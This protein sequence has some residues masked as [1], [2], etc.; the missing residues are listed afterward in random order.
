MILLSDI[1]LFM[2]SVS[3]SGRFLYDESSRAHAYYQQR[4]RELTE[5]HKANEGDAEDSRKDEEDRREAR[6]KKRRSRWGDEKPGA[7][8]GAPG[9]APPQPGVVIPQ[10]GQPGV[11]LPQL[12]TCS[13]VGLTLKIRQPGTT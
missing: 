10:L 11:V 1:S 5:Q 2:S 8:G 9:A 4:K 6:R 13:A 3:F 12:G 7:A